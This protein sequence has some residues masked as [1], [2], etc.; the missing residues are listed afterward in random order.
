[1]IKE[2]IQDLRWDGRRRPLSWQAA[3][4]LY[5]V[6][7]ALGTNGPAAHRIVAGLERALR[8]EGVGAARRLRLELACIEWAP[9]LTG[10]RRFWR[11]QVDERRGRL[12]RWSTARGW[13]G[14]IVASL[15][16]RIDAVRQH[17]PAQSSDG[18]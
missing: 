11:L 9:L 7:D 14:R 15:H 4:T 3:R 18:A 8:H 12:D 13:R 16:R 1:M 10:R 6:L 2:E 17:A 5:N